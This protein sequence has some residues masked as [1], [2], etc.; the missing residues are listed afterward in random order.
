MIEKSDSHQ[1]NVTDVLKKT[2]VKTPSEQLQPHGP[3][4]II[5]LMHGLNNFIF[6]EKVQT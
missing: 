5:K 2:Q 1:S 3:P 6:L 4:S